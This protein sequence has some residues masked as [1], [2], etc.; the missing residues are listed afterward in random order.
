M[1]ITENHL[2][3]KPAGRRAASRT[4]VPDQ[5]RLAV[6]LESAQQSYPE[7]HERGARVFFEDVA[8]DLGVTQGPALALLRA[9]TDEVYWYSFWR[10]A[11]MSPQ[12]TVISGRQPV[13]SVAPK[14]ASGQTA[15]SG[16]VQ[17]AVQR[18]PQQV[19]GHR[20]V[21]ESAP[22]T[23]VGAA[24]KRPAVEI[25]RGRL[26]AAAKT[27][28]KCILDTMFTY[29][30][31]RLRDATYAELMNDYK[32]MQRR[33]PFAHRL[34]F[35]LEWPDHDR[36]KLGELLSDDEAEALWRKTGGS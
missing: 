21:A 19:G 7:D 34:L 32:H 20:A 35:D 31:V 5:A 13:A 8:V 30:G 25:T 2:G 4:V 26:E 36:T 14:Q 17:D 12:P 22:E 1:P 16:G 29:T 10:E 6:L 24:P 15:P 9:L 23:V 18:G 11:G 28:V 27:A 3:D 33:M